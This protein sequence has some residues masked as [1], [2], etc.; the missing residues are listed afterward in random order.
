MIAAIEIAILARLSAASEAGN[1]LGYKYRNVESLPIDIDEGLASRVQS[2]PSAWVVFGGWQPITAF[3][4]GSAQVRCQYHVVVAA[5]N[6]RNEK[7]TRLGGTAAEVGSYQMAIDAAGL[8]AGQ[9]LG[10]QISPLT[11]GALTSLFTGLDKDRRKVS[12]F[13]LALSTECLVEALPDG[14]L[15]DF[16]TFHVNW[17]VPPHGGIDADPAEAGVQLPD[18]AHAD[19]TSHIVLPQET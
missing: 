15:T 4:D 10:L 18:D 7:S 3:G 13:A 14:D 2:F 9:T 8:L 1:V 16:A 19:A 17:D 5:E 11:I 12:L 6:A